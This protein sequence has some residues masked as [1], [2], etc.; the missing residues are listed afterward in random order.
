M[1]VSVLTAQH[2]STALCC[3][4]T[5]VAVEGSSR[6]EYECGQKTNSK[7]G[8]EEEY[9]LV[10]ELNVYHKSLEHGTLSV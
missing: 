4:D 1:D 8:V 6:Y 2:S 10:E 9:S 7:E 3:N 5:S